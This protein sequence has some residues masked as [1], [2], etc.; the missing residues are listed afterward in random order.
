MHLYLSPRV[1]VPSPGPDKASSLFSLLHRTARD[2]R[3]PSPG[4]VAEGRLGMDEIMSPL[5]F[6]FLKN[7]QYLI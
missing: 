5:F 3:E 7:K 4:E 2:G 6:N 1:G